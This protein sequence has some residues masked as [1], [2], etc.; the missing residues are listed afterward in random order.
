MQPRGTSTVSGA[1]LARCPAP[2]GS[3]AAGGAG[4][5]WAGARAARRAGVPPTPHG[6]EKRLVPSPA[7][8]AEEQA[9]ALFPPRRGDPRLAAANPVRPEVWT[10]AALGVSSR[11][12]LLQVSWLTKFL[13]APSLASLQL[14]DPGVWESRLGQGTASSGLHTL[15]AQILV[16]GGGAVF[17]RKWLHLRFNTCLFI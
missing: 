3:E 4:G 7:P 17:A 1:F 8:T 6:T 13:F 5:S 9:A 16:V 2:P 11:S 15:A 12:P 10:R 14:L